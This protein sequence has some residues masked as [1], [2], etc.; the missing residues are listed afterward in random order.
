M[1]VTDHKYKTEFILKNK[2]RKEQDCKSVGW[3]WN[4]NQHGARSFVLK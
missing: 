4:E 1:A 2:N 3:N